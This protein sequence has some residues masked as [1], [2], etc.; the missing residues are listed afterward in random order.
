MRAQAMARVYQQ[1]GAD[2]GKL[3]LCGGVLPGHRVSEAS[4]MAGMLEERGVPRG[5]M[6]QEAQSQ[7]TMGN[8]RCAAGLLGGA[9]GKRVL[10]VT[11]DYHLRRAVMT[12][13]RAGFD[14]DGFS[15]GAIIGVIGGD[16]QAARAQ[17]ARLRRMELC[18]IADLLL[19]WQ[20][21]GKSRPAWLRPA[22]D[23]IF[24]KK[25]KNA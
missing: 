23:T 12:A 25:E 6:L 15:A 2:C 10:V 1:L 3:V 5:A 18:Y 16:A 8:M 4:V 21:E 17:R 14:A 7:D 13:K 24:N 22:F 9:K 19:G 11:S 20:D